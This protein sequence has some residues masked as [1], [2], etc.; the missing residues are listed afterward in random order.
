M[1]ED[2]NGVVTEG[3]AETVNVAYMEI[4]RPG[5]DVIDVRLK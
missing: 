3:M 1:D 5:I 4:C 2:R